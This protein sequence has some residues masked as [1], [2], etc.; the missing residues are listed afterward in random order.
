MSAFQP[1]K[2]LGFNVGKEVLTDAWPIIGHITPLRK[3]LIQAGENYVRKDQKRPPSTLHYP[4]GVVRDRAVFGQAI[5]HTADR[6]LS[7]NVSR[8]V[9]RNAVD[10]LVGGLLLEGS[11]RS[12][13]DKFRTEHGHYPP[14]FLTVSPGHGCN[15]HCVG[16]YADSGPTPATLEWSIFDRILTESETLWGS[17]FCVISGGE[18]MVYRSEGNGILDAVEKHPNTF[19]L[20]YTNGTLIDDKVAE[21]MAKLGNITPAISVEGFR[22]RTDARRG[23]GVYDKVLAAMARLRRVGVPFGISITATRQNAE[24]ILSDEFLDFFFDQQGAL[25]GWIF[26]YMPIGRSYTL[27]L[28]PTPEQR[29]WMWGRSWEVIRKRRIFLADFWN[30]G[31]LADGCISA[32]RF[33]GGGFMYID[34]N[35][36]ISPCVF[37]PYSPV[38]IKDVYAKGG[39]LND[40]WGEPFF[41][42]LRTWQEQ[43]RRGDGHHGNWMMPCP[44]RDHQKELRR[45]IAQYEPDPTD[46]NARE[47][48]LDKEYARGMIKYDEDYKALSDPVWEEQYLRE[49]NHA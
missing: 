16:C 30:H 24:E 33:D 45:L 1:I 2:D 40:A 42:S 29:L 23:K 28:L 4:P 13:A 44:I 25:Y 39:T 17:R 48:L 14:G 20:M 47:A 35:G 38:N 31:T 3:A 21:R 15:L 27:D 46:V 5:I 12:I 49:S 8:A 10:N 18:P 43:Y 32:G 6:L 34:W 22:E 9:R 36:A 19:F 41:A 11:D 37:V 26:H 7:R